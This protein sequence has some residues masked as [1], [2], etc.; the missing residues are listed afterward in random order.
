MSN[1]GSAKDNLGKLFLD[2]ET[3]PSQDIRV[4]QEIATSVTPPG[5]MSKPETIA[6]W[7]EE[8]APDEI[9]KQWR[10]TA[11]NGTRGE[12]VVLSWA[13]DEGAPECLWRDIKEHDSERQL[14]GRFWK[15][16]AEENPL[17]WVG[18]NIVDFDLRFIWQRSIIKG[19]PPSVP[20]PVNQ[21]AWGG[22]VFDTMKTWAG[23]REMISLDNLCGCLGIDAG[24]DGMKGS[25]VW[26][27]VRDG[28]IEEVAEYCVRDVI[29]VREV[30]RKMTFR[31]L[32]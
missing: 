9:D 27:Y 12:I 18:H 7:R 20:I 30:Y 19:V 28:K 22:D 3:I 1:L 5:S 21:P 16:M 10:K 24:Q 17:L 29:A 14:L 2:A 32:G 15:K 4:Y 31:N 8:K 11:L 13:M 25:M 26:D 23:N 6:K